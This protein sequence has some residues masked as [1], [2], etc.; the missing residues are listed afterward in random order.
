MI[1]LKIFKP[2]VTLVLVLLFFSAG[3]THPGYGIV[4]DGK[5]KI[6]FTDIGR[7]TIWKMDNNNIISTVTTGKWTHQLFLDSQNNLYF[8]DEESTDNQNGYSFWKISE[9]GTL[10]Q[11]IP[12]RTRDNFPSDIF[13]MGDNGTLYVA[14]NTTVFQSTDDNHFYPLSLADKNQPLEKAKFNSIY[15]MTMGR[16]NSIYLIDRDKLKRIRNGMV[17]TI[18][19]DLIEENPSNLPIKNAPNIHSINRL[20]GLAL[21]PDGNI[22]AC[23]FGNRQVLK[24]SNKRELSIFYQSENPWSP[25]GVVFDDRGLIVKEHGFTEKQGWIGPRIILLREDGEKEILAEIM[26]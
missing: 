9:T 8:T 7:E 23:Y 18:A 11:L 15:S 12:P 20:F 22:Y 5:G 14:N 26:Q 19:A 17:E 2:L 6:Y 3:E 1:P 10:T 13:V 16:D 25:V 24:I 4:S 21:D